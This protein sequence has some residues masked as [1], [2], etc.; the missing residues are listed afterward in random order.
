MSAYVVFAATPRQ[1]GPP[2]A[3]RQTT[4]KR[5]SV[6]LAQRGVMEVTLKPHEGTVLVLR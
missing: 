2:H 3:S 1:P 4:R 5:L 6:P